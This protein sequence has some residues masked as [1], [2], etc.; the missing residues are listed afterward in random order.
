MMRRLLVRILVAWS[1]G[2]SS[3]R[4]T[5]IWISID[6]YRFDYPDK[7]DTPLMHRMMR[8]GAFSRDLVT[9]TPT[10]TFPSHVSEAT[11]VAAG[12]HGIVS[13]EFFDT[14]SK[15]LY[16]FPDDPSLVGAEPIW[17][18]AKR[19]GV[20]TAVYD[21]PLSYG[22][23]RG[24]RPDYTYEKFDGKPSDQERLESLLSIWQNDRG[25]KPLRVLMGYVKRTDGVGHRFGPDSREVEVAIRQTLR[26]GDI[27]R[28][29]AGGMWARC[30]WNSCIRWL[31]SC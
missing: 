20:R 29:L 24:V 31:R 26:S 11:G 21:W 18:T 4:A 5:V 19:Q 14:S 12:V 1:V 15:Q 8:E 2:C 17:I 28:R 6:G 30:M 10:I 16:K 23:F 3:H 25:K 7:T 13:N 9:I 27:R 22:T